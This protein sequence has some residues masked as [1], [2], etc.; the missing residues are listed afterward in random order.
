MPPDANDPEPP[1]YVPPEPPPKPPPRDPE[2][3]LRQ[4]W[5]IPRA[6][7]GALLAMLTDVVSPGGHL[8]QIA[9]PSDRLLANQVLGSLGSLAAKQRAF[10]ALC[11]SEPEKDL[12]VEF[13]KLKEREAAYEARYPERRHLWEPLPEDDDDDDEY[14][15]GDG[16]Y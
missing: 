3:E 9:T 12:D 15:V 13:R 14:E 16:R 2:P 10:D 1:P 8:A 6:A 5:P 11:A 4:G 7:R